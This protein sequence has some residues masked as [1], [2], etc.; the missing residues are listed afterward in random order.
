V[1]KQ[2]LE[3]RLVSCGV[4]SI[5]QVLIKW[6]SMPESLATCEDAGALK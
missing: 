3:K 1:P 2:I 5:V 6:S 4:R